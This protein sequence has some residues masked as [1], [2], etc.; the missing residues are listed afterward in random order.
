M[1]PI[2]PRIRTV[3]VRELKKKLKDLGR[4]SS[5]LLTSEE[6][7]FKIRPVGVVSKKDIGDLITESAILSCNMEEPLSAQN[8]HITMLLKNV[9]TLDPTPKNA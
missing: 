2:K 3:L 9:R 4:D 8:N 1:I 5:I 6:N 7:L